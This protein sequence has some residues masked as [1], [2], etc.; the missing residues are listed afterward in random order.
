[1]RF[2]RFHPTIN[3]IYFAAVIT[4]TIL[5]RHPVFLLISFGCSFAYSV[6]LGGVRALRFDLCM[7]P[8]ALLFA[9]WYAA[10]HHFG[11]TNLAQTWIGNQIT[12]ES[13]VYG[14][15]LGCTV[16]SV[17]MWMSC[18][19]VIFST[20]KVV[21]LFGR[22]S[23]RLSLFLAILLRMTQRIKGQ[24]RR[25]Q[26]AQ[27]AIGRGIHQG[28][29][30]RRLRNALRIGSI[31]LTWTLESFVTSSDSM[32][33]RGEP[34]RG[35]TAFSIYR[36]DNRDRALVVTMS[37]CLSLLMMGV[38]FHQT[39]IRCNPR[40]QFNRITPLSGVFYAGYLLLCL[41]PLLLQLW[42]EWQFQKKRRNL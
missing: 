14:L 35:R 5:F 36:F 29:P 15:M 18:V 32:R 24:A 23:P 39:R 9:L 40:I 42:G 16:A 33:A 12:L 8:L 6:K 20:D 1:M 38:L 34:L 3:L 7:L 22:L 13:L 19:H 4:C 10:F 37:A 26:E 27:R 17:M 31:V 2:D 25:V 41:L 28:N 11:V 21:Y 30:I